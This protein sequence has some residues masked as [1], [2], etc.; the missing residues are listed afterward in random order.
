[1]RETVDGWMKCASVIKKLTKKLFKCTRCIFDSKISN[2]GI[3]IRKILKFRKNDKKHVSY[4]DIQINFQL[5]HKKFHH[6]GSKHTH[7][8]CQNKNSNTDNS[9]KTVFRNCNDEEK[10]ESN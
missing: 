3:K 7:L 5:I 4:T 10:K 2:Y 6:S 9:T 8:S 1:M